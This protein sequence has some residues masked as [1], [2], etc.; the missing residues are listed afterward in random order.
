MLL[1]SQ[2]KIIRFIVSLLISYQESDSKE[3]KVQN[4]LLK[5]KMFLFF[6]DLFSRFC[7]NFGLN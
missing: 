7:R 3:E 4:S 2:E 5:L 1:V 6:S